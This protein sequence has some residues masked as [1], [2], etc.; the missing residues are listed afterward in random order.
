MN[1]Q[2]ANIVEGKTE[3]DAMDIQK[4]LASAP[5]R[6]P[7]LMV[8]RVVEIV[9]GESCVGIKN[10]TYNEPQFTGHFPN[11]PVMPGVLLIEAMAQ[12]GGLLVVSSDPSVIGRPVYFVSIDEA[13]FRKPVIP[14]DQ[15]R[16]HVRL[17]KRI[18]TMYRFEAECRVDGTVV[19]DAKFTAMCI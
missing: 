6:Y 17:A 8:D 13:R 16:M 19:C 3:L 15:V 4:V 11:Q 1:D 12:T 14:G 2:T 18:K 5:H 10:V 7:L 9:P